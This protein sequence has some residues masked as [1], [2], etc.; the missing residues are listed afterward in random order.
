[1]IVMSQLNQ[2]RRYA[3]AAVRIFAGRWNE[4]RAMDRLSAYPDGMLKDIG[5]SRGEISFAVRCGRN[6][7]RPRR[8]PASSARPQ[9]GGN[10]VSLRPALPAM[11]R[12]AWGIA[13]HVPEDGRR[14]R[15]DGPRR[16]NLR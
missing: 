4:R 7:D 10:I 1:M 11:V 6:S 15:S 9:N 3:A 16:G 2:A 5:V 14:E 12:H 8:H 13:E